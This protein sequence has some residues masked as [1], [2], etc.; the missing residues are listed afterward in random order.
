M[1]LVGKYW[2]DNTKDVVEVDGEMYVLHGWNGEKFYHC[3]KVLDCNGLDFAENIE[4]SYILTPVYKGVG[5]PDEEGNYDEFEVV[6]Y[7]V[8]A[9]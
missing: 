8:N 6:D 2:N 4:K 1:K 7:I 9:N 5:E 3:W